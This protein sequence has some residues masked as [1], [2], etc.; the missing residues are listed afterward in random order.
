MARRNTRMRLTKALAE[1]GG[2][3]V[4]AKVKEVHKGRAPSDILLNY[5]MDDSVPG[6]FSLFLSTQT[7][8]GWWSF[9][10]GI[11]DPNAAFEFKMRFG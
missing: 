11:S 2:E 5:L 6:Q 10:V 4:V 9:T 7:E 8:D 3:I 1:T